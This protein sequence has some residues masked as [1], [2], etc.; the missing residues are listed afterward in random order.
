MTASKTAK[1]Q[2]LISN[3]TVLLVHHAFLSIS[4]PSLHDHDVKPPNFTFSGGR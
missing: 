2:V 1:K 4:L 3:T